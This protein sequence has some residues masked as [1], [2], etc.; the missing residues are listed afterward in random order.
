MKISLANFITVNNIDLYAAVF[1][2]PRRK[3]SRIAAEGG[4]LTKKGGSDG[5]RCRFLLS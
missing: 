5:L 1:S 4:L 3:M 2:L